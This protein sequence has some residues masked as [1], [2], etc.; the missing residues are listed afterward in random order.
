MVIA[1]GTGTWRP[2]GIG[3]RTSHV[4]EFLFIVFS[5]VTAD[6]AQQSVRSTSGIPAPARRGTD[7]Q[8]G[9]PRR[10]DRLAAD[11]APGRPRFAGRR[12]VQ[13]GPPAGLLASAEIPD[14]PR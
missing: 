2:G 4:N 9:V 10:E 3:G 13:L 8:A 1:D 11:S 5:G 6:A 14:P 12:P 7:Q